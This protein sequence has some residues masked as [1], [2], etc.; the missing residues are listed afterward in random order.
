MKER[1]GNQEVSAKGELQLFSGEGRLSAEALR[2][3][4]LEA[5]A[6]DA[7]FV[8]VERNALSAEREDILRVYPR[9]R[10]GQS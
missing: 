6:D 9:T 1:T 10:A 2:R 5:G 8:E 7:G 4:C 3:L